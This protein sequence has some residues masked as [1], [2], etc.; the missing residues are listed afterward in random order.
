M[1][2]LTATIAIE[3]DDRKLAIQLEKAKRKTRVLAESVKKHF[4]R[5]DMFQRWRK[6][7]GKI[8]L[9][10]LS[11]TLAFKVLGAKLL[12]TAPILGLLATAGAKVADSFLNME[13][14]SGRTT[15]AVRRAD[16]TLVKLTTTTSQLDKALTVL[17]IKLKR[18]YNL[19]ERSARASKAFWRGFVWPIK[20]ASKALKDLVWPMKKI[21]AMTKK[22][23]EYMMPSLALLLQPKK[24]WRGV[25]EAVKEGAGAIDLVAESLERG[26]KRAKKFRAEYEKTAKSIEKSNDLINI[27]EQLKS[28]EKGETI[29]ENMARLRWE[30]T[31]ERIKEAESA[32]KK[33]GETLY[34]ISGVIVIAYG[35]IY[36]TIKWIF[37]GILDITTSVFR[38]IV[39]VSRWTKTAVVASLVGMYLYITKA[40]MDYEDAQAK[41]IGTVGTTR[42]VLKQMY[43]AIKYVA[44]AIGK[45]FLTNIKSIALAITE[46][47]VRNRERVKI[48]AES[49][50]KYL[51]AI[52]RGFV[53]WIKYLRKDWRGGVSVALKVIIE[54]FKGFAE[55][56]VAIMGV[57][58]STAGKA[59]IDAMVYGVKSFMPSL[60]KM[61]DEK[62]K[63]LGQKLMKSSEDAARS[64]ERLTG[65]PA[66]RPGFRDIGLGPRE[67]TEEE[68]LSARLTR[69]ARERAENIKKILEDMPTW[70]ETQLGGVEQAEE[71][72]EKYEKLHQELME[73]NVEYTRDRLAAYSEMYSGMNEWSQKRYNIEMELLQREKAEYIRAGVDRVTAH[74]WMTYQIMEL[75]K[76]MAIA[77]ED[78]FAGLGAAIEQIKNDMISWGEI[79]ETVAQTL[80]S[81]L[82]SAFY[83]MT[84][85]AKEFDEAMNDVFLS[86]LESFQRMITDM[87]AQQ[88][89]TTILGGLGGLF[90]GG[91]TTPTT[92]QLSNL[93]G[94]GGG[95]DSLQHG[96]EVL[97]TG[98]AIVHK[99]ETFSGVD[100][101]APKVTVNITKVG[102][103]FETEVDEFAQMD[104]HVVNIVVKDIV[105]GGKL[106][107][108]TGAT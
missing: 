33:T 35:K 49:F 90:G 82:G 24:L 25:T 78:F 44:A 32:V 21:E 77:S 22:P 98:L 40:A 13:K 58:G 80:T 64:M 37:E 94:Y 47:L 20:Q 27:D 84:T 36:S 45:P 75:D 89:M 8:T 83:D 105:A 100:N 15:K 108:L 68:T 107:Q 87:L 29:L 99:G 11:S 86:V 51:T 39:D 43:A 95:F 28:F 81:S 4:A 96:G 9:A 30:R 50:V 93:G 73:N 53:D 23:E 2:F 7:I 92:T 76:K 69:I 102:A 56:L 38:K 26:E 63:W 60:V 12:W 97:R 79:G 1:N 42:D 59:L 70:G 74:E 106:A 16:G 6:S 61:M 103:D 46:F 5:V 72:N 17:P 52:E 65:I 18:I 91:G 31:L 10:A 101:G 57:A 55:M 85:E 34:G 104:E 19:F 48:W 66:G 3:A 88:L 62:L 71:A 14:W 41:I 67:P 54:L